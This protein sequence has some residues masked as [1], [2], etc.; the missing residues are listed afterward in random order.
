MLSFDKF[1]LDKYSFDFFPCQRFFIQKINIHLI[2]NYGSKIVSLHAYCTKPKTQESRAS[3][4]PPFP[5]WI[6]IGF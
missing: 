1:V 2:N 3:Q 4:L 5:Q 6:K